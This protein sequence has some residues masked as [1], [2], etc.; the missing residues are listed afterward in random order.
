MFP[1]P[2]ETTAI[3]RRRLPHWEVRNGTYFVTLCLQGAI[4]KGAIESIHR[5]YRA[6]E[7]ERPL[8]YL[9]RQRIIF[10]ELE[11]WLHR[12][13]SSRWL[14]DP[15]VARMIKTSIQYNQDHRIWDM[16]EYVLMPNHGHLTFRLPFGQGESGL[17]EAG[18]LAGIMDNF[19]RY[20]GRRAQAIL[21]RQGHRFWQRE[22]FD[23][24]LRTEAEQFRVVEY[25]RRN[26]V[27]A[28]YVQNY[29]DW[30]YGSWNR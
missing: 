3:Y 25:I 18:R 22:W 21:R 4:S 23:H 19:K 26:P 30:P 20:T 29:R 15:D 27:T 12:N 10:G 6:L 13:P 8:E 9:Q 17:E 11:R 2:G 28:G 16:L 7:R 24:W 5:T 14:N 1:I